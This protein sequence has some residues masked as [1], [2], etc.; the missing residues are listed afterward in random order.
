MRYITPI[1]LL[2]LVGCKEESSRPTSDTPQ[3]EKTPELTALLQSKETVDEQFGVL[4]GQYK[5][6]LDRSDS[7][8]G[9]DEN[10]DGI[11]DDIEAFINALEVSEPV[12]NALKQ[13]AR[14]TQENLYYDF[15]EAT[16]SNI[17]KA[18]E[19]S[20]K[21]DKVLACKDFIGMSVDDSINTSETITSLTYN[22]K[23]RTMAY[24]AYNHL[25]DGSV[26][27]LLDAKEEYC[28]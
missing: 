17:D 4:Y 5:H 11:R 25:L 22:T 26:S 2:A 15:S 24:L 20:R 18:Y 8:P 13:D 6:L 16:E 23:A 19:I 3:I 14:Q 28:E 21:Y 12:R 1:L 9:P 7:L 10:D 27:T